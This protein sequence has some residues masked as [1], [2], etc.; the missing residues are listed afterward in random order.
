MSEEKKREPHPIV[1]QALDMATEGFEP[2][3]LDDYA[4]EQLE[5]LLRKYFG[6]EELFNAVIDLIN[7]AALLEKEGSPKA[8][9]KLMGVAIIATD[10]LKKLEG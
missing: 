1:K 2:I 7:L 5:E 8:A 3:E 10:E 4:V 9:V 6:K